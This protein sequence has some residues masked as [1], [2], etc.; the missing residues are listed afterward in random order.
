[1]SWDDRQWRDEINEMN[2]RDESARPV[3]PSRPFVH[4]NPYIAL[5]SFGHLVVAYLERFSLFCVSH[6]PDLSRLYRPSHPCHSYTHPLIRS[7]PPV[8][9]IHTPLIPSR[10]FHY[11][12]TYHHVRFATLHSSLLSLLTRSCHPDLY[13]S[14]PSRAE[15]TTLTG[16]KRWSNS[17][18]HMVKS[19][20]CGLRETIVSHAE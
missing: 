8:I 2:E 4:H 16:Q 6:H 5:H 19:A 11:I 12:H 7:F 13:A 1:M 18:R 20:R 15:W 9:E 14:R 3:R 10:P 17:S